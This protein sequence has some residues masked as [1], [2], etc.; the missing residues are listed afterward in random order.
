HRLMLKGSEELDKETLEYRL[1]TPDDERMFLLA[2]AF[3]RGYTLQQLQDLTKIDWWFLDK[4]EGMVKFEDR[5][6]EEETLSEQTLYEAK[7]M[8]FTDRA[9]A[10]LRSEG[11]PGGTCTK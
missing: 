6:R 8:G 3:R 2:E 5:I 4:L 7:R 1:Q 9:I 10:E 11:Q